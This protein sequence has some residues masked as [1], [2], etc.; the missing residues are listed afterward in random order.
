MKYKTFL[1]L[2]FCPVTR[3]SFLPL[4]APFSRYEAFVFELATSWKRIIALRLLETLVEETT[5]YKMNDRNMNNIGMTASWRWIPPRVAPP[6]P[7]PLAVPPPIP[8]I[9]TTLDHSDRNGNVPHRNRNVSVLG[10]LQ[11]AC[12][13]P[14]HVA[15]ESP[16]PTSPGSPSSLM[17]SAIRQL[18]QIRATAPRNGVKAC[19]CIV[20]LVLL[21]V[22]LGGEKGV[23]Q[24]SSSLGGGIRA[25]TCPRMG[26]P[27]RRTPLL[28][29]GEWSL[30]IIY[31]LAMES[32][33][34][35]YFAFSR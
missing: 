24:R 26:F 3:L 5:F 29:L 4:A 11:K 30:L 21:Q 28:S 6:P 7:A 16:T 18:L 31:Q 14:Q 8:T 19:S 32:S 13:T 12:T 20:H 9:D 23:R 17:E 15:Q 35:I 34:S 27:D 1:L 25:V 10:V 2:S 22:R 33:C